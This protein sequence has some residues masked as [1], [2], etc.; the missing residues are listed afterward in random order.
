MPAAEASAS[1][2]KTFPCTAAV[3][4]KSFS[5]AGRRSMRAAMIPCTDSG[6]LS[7]IRTPACS[8]RMNSSA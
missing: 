2:Q 6:S 3:C 8:I 5:V 7:S 1:D 4:S